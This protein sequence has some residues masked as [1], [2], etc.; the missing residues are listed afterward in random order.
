MN[1]D[2]PFRTIERSD[3]S[4]PLNGLQFVT[5]KSKSLRRRG[6]VS[7][8]A[9]PD[10]NAH[11]NLPVVILL[12]G[13]WASHWSWM[14]KGKAHLTAARLIAAGEIPP[15]ALLSPSDGLW[16]DGSG[17]VHH[18]LENYEGWIIDEMPTL[19][20]HAISGC[21]SSSPLFIAGLSMGGFGAMT[22][23]GKYSERISGVGA[24]SSITDVRQL[25]ALIEESR[26]G[27]AATPSDQCV[28]SA[29]A[30]A[31]NP[32]PPIRFDC[33]QSDLFIE[34]NRRLHAELNDL[35][36]EHEYAESAGGHDWAYWEREV[37]Q[38]FRFFGRIIKARP[39]RLRQQF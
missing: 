7:L 6:D 33:G 39:P 29:L 21:S 28:V 18:E 15:L 37:E 32:L 13:V 12:H 20:Q 30:G 2:T 22:I 11:R 3:P 1:G 26:T 9:P 25:D 23:A 27:W 19:A 8:W 31:K 17:Y 14:L 38:T 35:G 16:G 24:H 5:I 4:V 34:A 36:I 10:A